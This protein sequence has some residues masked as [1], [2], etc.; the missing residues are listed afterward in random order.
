MLPDNFPREKNGYLICVKTGTCISAGTG[1]K[2][3][4]RLHGTDGDSRVS[5]KTYV[6]YRFILTVNSPFSK[7]KEISGT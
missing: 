3:G 7:K 5:F 1:A 6:Q 2:V 4:V